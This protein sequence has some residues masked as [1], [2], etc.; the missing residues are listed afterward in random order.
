MSQIIDMLLT[1]L[2][3][4][5]ADLGKDGGL[6]SPSIY[7][8]AQVLRFCPPEEGI[9]SALEWLM[10]QQQLDGG[11]GDPAVPLAR[12]VPTL[13]SLLTLQ[14]YKNGRATHEAI[15]AGVTFLQQRAD[16]WRALCIDNLPIAVELILPKLVEEAID[17]GL[18]LSLHPYARLVELGN[19]KR[20]KI[21]QRPPVAGTPPTYSWEAWG[22]DPTLPVIDDLGS[23]GTSPAATAAWLHAAV[24]CACLKDACE[25]GGHYLTQAS[26]ATGLNI[27]GVVPV[28]WPI[29]RFEQQYALYSLLLVNLSD[30][31]QLR[32]VTQAQV[33]NLACGFRSDGVS[34]NDSFAS[35]GD[36][37]AV[38]LIVLQTM[39]YNVDAKII[40]GQYESNGLFCTFLGEMNPS[41]FTTAHAIHA[42]AF[43]GID[44]AE[45]QRFLL[46]RQ[47]PDG[48]W[49]TDKWHSSWLYT[50]LEVIL[51]FD[52]VGHYE[53]IQSAV[54][55]LLDYQHEDSGWGMNSKSTT[56]ETAYSVLALYKLW[57]IGLLDENALNALRQGYQWLVSEYRPF[58]RGNEHKLWI[59]KE[60][61]KPYRIDR[62]FE[63]SAMLAMALEEAEF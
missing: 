43:S 40:L 56:T 61:Y 41:V 47:C 16:E 32:N 36:D 20:K 51:A 1:E 27:P 8:T 4:L 52:Q 34:W 37:T 49:P 2:S 46:Q 42:L 63:L 30:H 59:G 38:A 53:V 15:E 29:N 50:T 7:D 9:A 62:A 48:R 44:T 25:A 3:A 26:A 39:G 60:L 57:R 10:A 22:S 18:E 31:P 55:A 33:R 23:I 19:R 54:E 13:A 6:I 45:P 21:A 58:Q 35:D 17:S 14:T 12:H 28:V 24:G 5:I 11:W